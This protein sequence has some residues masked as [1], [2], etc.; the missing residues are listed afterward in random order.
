MPKPTIRRGAL[1][2]R[3]ARI[4]N[5]RQNRNQA[6]LDKAVASALTNLW[7]SDLTDEEA[8]AEIDKLSEE[9]LLAKWLQ[10]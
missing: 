5:G 4:K 3:S 9:E 7:A 8:Q 1:K 2:N 6:D 10:G